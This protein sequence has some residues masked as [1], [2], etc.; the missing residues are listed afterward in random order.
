MRCSY[1]AQGVHQCNYSALNTLTR[2]GFALSSEIAAALQEARDENV[3]QTAAGAKWTSE[4]KLRTAKIID[5]EEQARTQFEIRD[6]MHSVNWQVRAEAGA[7]ADMAIKKVP[8]CSCYGASDAND[9]C[10]CDA[11]TNKYSARGWAH[12]KRNFAQCT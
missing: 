11:V 10:T 7:A 4:A 5:F 3:R 8:T 1:N 2:E 6:M 9:C 12:D